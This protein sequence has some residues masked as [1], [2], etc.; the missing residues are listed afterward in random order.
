MTELLVAAWAVACV[1]TA[2]EELLISL[3]KWRGLLALS[4]S[5]VACLV[6]RPLGW[7]QIFYVLSASFIGLISSVVVENLITGTPERVARGLP[8][9]VPPL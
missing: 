8:K 3:G 1:L 6:L 2:I 7:D 4:M 5:T 9:K